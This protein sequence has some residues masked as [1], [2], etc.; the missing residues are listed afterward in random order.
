MT[1]RKRQKMM[2]EIQENE[3]FVTSLNIVYKVDWIGTS[4]FGVINI[5]E[6]PKRKGVTIVF[7]KN[8]GRPVNTYD[9]EFL[10]IITKEDNPEYF[11]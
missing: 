9:E 8:S 2:K 11:L 10:K 4:T 7:N 3:L 6:Y 1:Y 5:K